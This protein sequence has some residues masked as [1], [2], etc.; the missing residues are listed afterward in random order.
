MRSGQIRPLVCQ[1][2]LL[3]SQEQLKNDIGAIR[4]GQSKS[5]R[6]KTVML[7]KKMKGIIAIVITADPESI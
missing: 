1:D 4:A 5:K 6:R 7:D 3:S 2:E